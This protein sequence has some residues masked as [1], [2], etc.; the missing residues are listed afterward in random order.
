M[1]DERA[2]SEILERLYAS[3]INLRIEWVWDGGIAWKLGDELNGWGASGVSPSLPD[4]AKD[5]G[6][7]AAQRHPESEFATWWRRC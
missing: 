3:E 7:A 2:T 4:A 1:Q 6:T 5:V